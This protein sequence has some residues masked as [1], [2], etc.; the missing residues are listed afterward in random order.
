MSCQYVTQTR[1]EFWM[2]LLDIGPIEL[3]VALHDFPELVLITNVLS[4]Q[5][6][7]NANDTTEISLF[8]CL[9]FLFWFYLF[10][11]FFLSFL[12]LF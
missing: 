1:H 2:S 12:S 4:C 7:V 3:S 10:I 9:L 6:P 8:V 11:F 5:P